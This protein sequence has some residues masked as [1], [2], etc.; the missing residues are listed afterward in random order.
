MLGLIEKGD[1][2]LLSFSGHGVHIDG[3]SYLCP[4]DA[5]LED[6]KGT[7]VSLDKVYDDLAA[8]KASLKFMIVDAC[9]NDPHVEGQRKIID[10]TR[11]GCAFNESL[12]KPPEGISLLASCSPGEFAREDPSLGHGVFIHF[13][14][15]GLQ[16]KAAND[17][18]I[19]SLMRLAEYTTRETQK[20]VAQKYVAAQTPYFRG[21]VSG[22]VELARI[23]R[24]RPRPQPASSTP[25]DDPAL[26]LTITDRTEKIRID[27]KNAQAYFDRGEAWYKKGD[28]DKAI[29]DFTEALRISPN[30]TGHL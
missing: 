19:V 25:R 15:E 18:G 26:E 6:P 5:K 27:S 22:P 16:G 17:E 24:I 21:E 3:H 2:L 11:S 9:R 1:T 30:L 4:N 23:E 28:Y 10:S 29:A 14:L 13:I 8:C 12:E 7:M 20:Y